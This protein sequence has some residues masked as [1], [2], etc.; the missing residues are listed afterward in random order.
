MEEFDFII[1]YTRSDA[2]RDKVII[3]ISD[4][5]IREA[6]FKVPIAMTCTLF[7]KYIKTEL[8]TQSEPGR[9]WDMLCILNVNAQMAGDSD[10]IYFEV[11]FLMNDEKEECVKLK[12][13]IGPGDTP[14]PVLTVMLPDE[15]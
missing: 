10:T 14:E 12:A 1:K 5:M 11:I 7:E 4:K 9:I 2:I 3:P 8:P 13:I 15:D 6:G